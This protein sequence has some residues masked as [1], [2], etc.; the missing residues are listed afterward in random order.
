MIPKLSV[1]AGLPLNVGF[2]LVVIPARCQL[3]DFD[4]LGNRAKLSTVITEVVTLLCW[5]SQ[6]PS[7]LGDRSQN[8]AR[9]ASS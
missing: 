1:A 7:F 9:P 6:S 5:R 4:P 2:G 8:T 3:H